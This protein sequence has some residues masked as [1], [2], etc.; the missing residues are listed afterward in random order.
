MTRSEIDRERK[1][2]EG[3]PIHRQARRREHQR[4]RGGADPALPATFAARIWS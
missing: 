1:E 3:D 4:L 2:L